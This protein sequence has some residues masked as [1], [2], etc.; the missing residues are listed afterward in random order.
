MSKRYT[1]SVVEEVTK[2]SEYKWGVGG[3]IEVY[4]QQ[5]KSQYAIEEYRFFVP[6]EMYDKFFEMFDGLETDNPVRIAMDWK[7]I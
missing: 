7:I 4:D 2:N 5:N 3:R 6:V 1:F